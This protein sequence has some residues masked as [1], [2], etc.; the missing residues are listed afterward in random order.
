MSFLRAGFLAGA[1]YPST[2]YCTGARPPQARPPQVGSSG[3]SQL[4]KGHFLP[5]S[6]QENLLSRSAGRSKDLRS[7]WIGG[8]SGKGALGVERA[9]DRVESALQGVA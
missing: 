9:T 3:R 5:F 1:M 4:R 6:L 7:A 8:A 2:S